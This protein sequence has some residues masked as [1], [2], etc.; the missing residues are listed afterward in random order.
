MSTLKFGWI[1]PMVG[2]PESDFVPLAMYQEQ[3]ILPTAMEHFDSLWACDHFYG[4]Q[5]PTD[6]FLEGWT[7]LTWLAAKFPKVQLCHHV[8]GLGYRNPALTAKMAAT[9]QTLSGGRFI[10][11][12]GAGWRGEE[13]GFYGYDFPRPAVRIAQLDEAVQL[14]RRM[15]TEEAA[16]FHGTYFTIETAYAPPRP[17][18]TPPVL[19]GGKGEQ[20]MLP[21]IGRQ[22]DMWNT[23][24]G[25]G[26]EVYRRRR[27]IV[28]RSAEGA[29]RDPASITLTVTFEAPLPR[30]SDESEQWTEK[31]QAWSAEGVSHFVLDFGHVTSTEPVMRFVE[32]VMTPLRRA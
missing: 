14:M 2:P 19:I 10:L 22:A 4:F 25:G 3:H 8:L 27:D 12:I 23:S 32:E 24:D 20:L 15:W 30:T 17:E 1:T 13:Y 16:S 7:T 21:L 28:H 26:L 9:L 31:L 6:P 29:G 18:P 5:R 11:G